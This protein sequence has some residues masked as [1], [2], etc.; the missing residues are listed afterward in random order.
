[1]AMAR[2]FVWDVDRG[3]LASVL[4]GHTNN[5]VRCMFAPAGY[6]LATLSWDGSRAPLG[7]GH[8]RA[9]RQHVGG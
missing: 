2:V 8:G 5:V 6:L 3:R 7:C 9:A 1:M 4:Q